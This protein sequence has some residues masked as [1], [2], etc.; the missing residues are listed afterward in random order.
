MSILLGECFALT[1]PAQGADYPEERPYLKNIVTL[2]GVDVDAVVRM[3][4]N[5]LGTMIQIDLD[6]KL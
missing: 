5:R 2:A 4:T 6:E 3:H 1:V